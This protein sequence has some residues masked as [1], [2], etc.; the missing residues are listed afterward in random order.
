MESQSFMIGVDNLVLA[1]ILSDTKTETVYDTPF[2]V[3]G[4]TEIAITMNN[5]SMT[6]YA[7]DAAYENVQQQGDVD[8]ACSLAGLDGINRAEATGGSYNASTG[9][10]DYDGSGI[11]AKYALGYRRQK[12]NGAYRYTWFMKGSFSRPDSTASTKTGSISQQPMQ[13]KYRAL[14]RLSDKRLDRSVDSDSVNLPNGVTNDTLA[15]ADTGWFSSPDYVPVATGTPVSDFTTSE[16]VVSN[17]ID[18]AWSAATGATLI[19]VQVQTPAGQWEYITPDDAVDADSTSA[20]V[21]GLIGGNEY[22]FRL[23][24]VG[25]TYA[26]ISNTSTANA[27]V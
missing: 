19:R 25:G 18:L 1:K 16:G 22:T 6:I 20:T 7:D 17:S 11:P 9:V 15:N 2:A 27:T 10:V 3:P 14:N 5:S 23:V 26:G 8:V 24:V 4:V 13:Y 21:S 12:A